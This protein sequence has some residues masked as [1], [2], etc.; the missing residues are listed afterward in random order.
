MIDRI[1][2]DIAERNLKVAALICEDENGELKLMHYGT[3]GFIA[4]ISQPVKSIGIYENLEG[5]KIKG[6]GTISKVKA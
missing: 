6:I 4:F 1:L 5:N 2:K 3:D